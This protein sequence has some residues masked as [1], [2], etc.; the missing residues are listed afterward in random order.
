MMGD[1]INHISALAKGFTVSGA[2][3]PLSAFKQLVSK[4]KPPVVFLSSL[5]SVCL[6]ASVVSKAGNYRKTINYTDVC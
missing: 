6:G 1:F 3:R 4:T 2:V 5:L